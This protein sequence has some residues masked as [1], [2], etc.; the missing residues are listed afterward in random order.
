MAT[1]KTFHPESPG[2]RRGLFVGP[3]PVQEAPG[4]NP[5]T[6]GLK[7]IPSSMPHGGTRIP[8]SKPHPMATGQ[9]FRPE[10]RADQGCSSKS[11]KARGSV[12]SMTRATAITNPAAPSRQPPAAT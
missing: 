12:E 1:G 8:G 9:A 11:S 3:A 2:F 4:G 7:T 6:P 5:G 10:P